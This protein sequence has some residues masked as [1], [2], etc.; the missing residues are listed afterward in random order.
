MKIIEYVY[1]GRDNTND[2][3]LT[4]DGETVDLSSVTKMELINDDWSVDSDESPT[5]F[6]WSQGNGIVI[7]TLG[8]VPEIPGGKNDV[9][10]IVYDPDNTSG[11]H[12]GDFY[13][14]V[15]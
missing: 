12:W 6:D 3:K 7:I 1:K 15:E 14:Y 10:L 4:A 9:S 2:L 11:I 13:L 8:G 5:V